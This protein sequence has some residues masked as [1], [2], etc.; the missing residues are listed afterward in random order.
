[1]DYEKILEWAFARH[2]NPWSWYI[3][4]IFLILLCYSA[5]KRSWKRIIII[6]ILMTSSMVWFPPPE[7]I[8]PQ[9]QEVLEFEKKVLSSP[10]TAIVTLVIMFL[11]LGSVLFSFWKR[12]LRVALIILNLAIIGKPIL[13]YL[14]TG[15]AGRGTIPVTIFGL[16]IVNLLAFGIYWYKKRNYHKN[17]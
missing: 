3:R 13:S 5:Y 12:S 8:D 1:M 14:F 16:V 11:F 17:H 10:G 2:L 4:P 15:G 6:F 7:T 9:M